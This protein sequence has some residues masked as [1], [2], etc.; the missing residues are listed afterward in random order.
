[1]VDQRLVQTRLRLGHPGF[2][3]GHP[4]L[5]LGGAGPPF[6]KPCARLREACA[7]CAGIKLAK[8]LACFHKAAFLQWLRDDGGCGFGTNFNLTLGLCLAA[9]NDCAVDLPRDRADGYD[10]DQVFG[11]LCTHVI[12][13]CG[14]VLSVLSLARIGF[15]LCLHDIISRKEP[16]Q[17][18]A[19]DDH[20]IERHSNENCSKDGKDTHEGLGLVC[21]AGR[22]VKIGCMSGMQSGAIGGQCC[23]FAAYIVNY[24]EL[25]S[26]D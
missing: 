8:Q 10:L 12:G 11:F 13:Y 23:P 21:R 22:A 26:S 4:G 16:H 14:A 1:M 9:Q 3:F 20:K 25:T 5:R 6:V 24:A 18:L 7:A 15:D 2:C 17:P 19:V